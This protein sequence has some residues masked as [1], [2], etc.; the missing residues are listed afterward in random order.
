MSV[1]DPVQWTNKRQSRRVRRHL[2]DYRHKQSPR[3][4]HQMKTFSVLLALCAGNSPVTGEFPSQKLVT[5]SFDVFFHLCLNKR[6]S[7]QSWG[8]WFE[9]PSRS[10]WCHYNDKIAILYPAYDLH[11]L[12][13]CK[14]MAMFMV[15]KYLNI[16]WKV[17]PSEKNSVTHIGFFI[18]FR[19]FATRK[20][21]AR[22]LQSVE[23]LRINWKGSTFYVIWPTIINDAPCDL[24]EF[25][26]R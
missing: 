8:W 24:A 20:S 18:V 5:R 23:K 19:S 1:Q 14:S 17:W 16:V 9:M 12:S 11:F 22:Y 3:W 6:L 13:P 7:K 10:L 26:C 4:R 21:I 2:Y 25:H 15:F